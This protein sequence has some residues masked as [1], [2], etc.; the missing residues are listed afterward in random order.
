MKHITVEDSENTC[1]Y[2]RKDSKWNQQIIEDAS[3]LLQY[4]EWVTSNHV[5]GQR[6]SKQPKLM[7]RMLPAFHKLM[8][9]IPT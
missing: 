9:T 6:C 4:Q 7:S 8:E 2:E 1:K 3:S 5:V